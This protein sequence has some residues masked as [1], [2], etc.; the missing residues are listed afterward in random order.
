[1][2]Q[3]TGDIPYAAMYAGFGELVACLDNLRSL[4]HLRVSGSGKSFEQIN[5]LFRRVAQLMRWRFFFIAHS[6]RS[7]LLD[8]FI[9][10]FLTCLE[11]NEVKRQLEYRE[12]IR[13]L[14]DF[15]RNSQ[16]PG[17]LEQRFKRRA[18]AVG[19]SIP[20]TSESNG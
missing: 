13:E 17:W 18:I 12:Y 2:D 7:S 10:S 20:A 14:G 8:A 9:T 1:M 6:D 16:M 4:H 15:W 19:S 11:I 3:K 5:S